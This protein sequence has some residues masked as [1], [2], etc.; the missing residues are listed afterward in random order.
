VAISNEPARE[1]PLYETDIRPLTPQE[2]EQFRKLA[3]DEFGLDLRPGKEQLVSARLAKKM[4][5]LRLHSYRDYYRHVVED[6]SKEALVAMID[7]LTTNHTSFFREMAH[8][9]FLKKNIMPA[10]RSRDRIAI[11]SAACSTGEEPY[12]IAFTLLDELGAA[13]LPRIQILGTDISTRVLATAQRGAYPA[14]RFQGA[15][16]QQ[17]RNYLLRGEG[18]WKS[19][20]LVKKEIRSAV[21][22]RRLNLM[23]KISHPSP[24]PVIF[25]RNVMIYFDRPTQQSVVQ[26]LSEHLEP[27]GYLLIGHAES[28]NSIQ[29]SLE[30]VRPAIYRKPQGDQ[31]RK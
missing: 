22:F 15:P 6:T 4:R 1:A 23:E 2:F 13:A 10:L 12:S 14:E 24:F 20:Y 19:W 9:E 29:H 18:Q 27:G 3:Y 30:Y 26:R 16:P 31:D 8:F 25:C 7:A 21:T 28:L 5:Q 17:L 11:W